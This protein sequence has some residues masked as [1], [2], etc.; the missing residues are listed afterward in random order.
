MITEFSLFDSKI[1]ID[2]Q[3]DNDWLLKYII[4]DCKKNWKSKE[5]IFLIWKI[6]FIG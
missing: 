4:Y 6:I 3:T 2:F 5:L 1:L